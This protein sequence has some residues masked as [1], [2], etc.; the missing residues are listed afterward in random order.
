MGERRPWHPAAGS[1]PPVPAP[2]ERQ[3]RVEPVRVWDTGG[4]CSPQKGW[5]A[6]R[7]ESRVHT[8]TP[9]SADRNPTY[10]LFVLDRDD[11]VE[12]QPRA[13]NKGLSVGVAAATRPQIAAHALNNGEHAVSAQSNV[14]AKMIKRHKHLRQGGSDHSTAEQ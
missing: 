11:V 10:H 12:I 8:S 5:P 9:V 6:R 2:P 13:V 1:E 7:Q 4:G 14:C 3:A